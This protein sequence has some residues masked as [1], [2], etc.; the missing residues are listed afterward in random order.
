MRHLRT[1][2]FEFQGYKLDVPKLD[3][4]QHLYENLP[5]SSHIFPLKTG[6]KISNQTEYYLHF[7]QKIKINRQTLK[8]KNHT[9]IQNIQ[10]A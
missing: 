10:F 4:N 3:P 8:K 2:I 7:T 6:E 9:L 5:N 1:I